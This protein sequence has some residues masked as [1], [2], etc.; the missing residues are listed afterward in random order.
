MRTILKDPLLHFLLFGAVIYI[1]STFLVSN[2][3][4]KQQISISAGQIQHLATLYRKTWQR[5]PTQK[6]LKGIVDDYV[7]EQASYLE[8]VRLG[9]DRDD[10]VIKR[11]LR[12]KLDFIAE[13]S[14]SKSTPTDEQLNT[15]ITANADKF[16]QPP[17]LTLRQIYLDPKIYGDAS[18]PKAKALLAS[19]KAEPKQDIT[20]LDN[21]GLFKSHYKAQST[22]EFN[23]LLGKQFT[24]NV[25][26]LAPHSWHGQIRS[27]YGIHFVYI[28]NKTTGRLP[29]LDEIRPR[30]M[31]EWENAQRIKTMDDFYTNLLS[32][33]E[34]SIAPFE[35]AKLVG[36]TQAS[37]SDKTTPG[38]S[39][40]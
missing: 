21:R 17:I 28:E 16:S 5:A 27:S 40:E 33:F 38:K 36:E 14:F 15:F 20:L 3:N 10:I 9:L 24:N 12:Q 26:K 31:Y 37:A 22:L 8:G 4:N 32:Q 6:E 35:S 13:E 1:V 18:S 34:I 25:L 29:P 23:R 2:D 11:R 19:L 30:V 39:S 7:L